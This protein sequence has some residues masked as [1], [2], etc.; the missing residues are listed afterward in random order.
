MTGANYAGHM[1]VSLVTIA[2]LS[3]FAILSRPGVSNC[4]GKAARSR[5]RGSILLNGRVT[6]RPFA[7]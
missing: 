7:A 2:G 1:N 6:H 3:A 4:H 5:R